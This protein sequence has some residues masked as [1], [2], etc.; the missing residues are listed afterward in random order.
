[1]KIQNLPTELKLQIVHQLDPDSTL[2]FALTCRQHG[3]VCRSSLEHHT[4]LFSEWQVLNLDEDERK[5]REGK[6]IWC[7]LDEILRDPQKGKYVREITLPLNRQHRYGGST[8]E[9]Q[10]SSL[11]LLSRKEQDTLKEATRELH[12]LYTNKADENNELISALEEHLNYDDA[13]TALLIHQLPVL[14][15]LRISGMTAS[16]IVPLI[17]Q[18]SLRQNEFIKAPELPL[19]TLSTAVITPVIGEGNRNMDWISAFFHLPSL[20]IFAAHFMTAASIPKPRLMPH[21]N[22]T[23]L[24]FYHCRF[25][26]EVLDQIL[27]GIKALRKFAY[28]IGSYSFP[29][30]RYEPKKLLATIANQTKDS[31]EELILNLQD[32]R[33][34]V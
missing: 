1:M 19:Q 26:P 16:R 15:T 13:I 14:K 6:T 9:S 18:I 23:V 17:D 5:K 30:I 4:K 28:I 2:Q 24:F 27:A 31:L 8:L 20:Q 22:I 25:D 34:E 21:S 3:G 29:Y 10:Q 33:E 11:S 12:Q 7:M 32:F